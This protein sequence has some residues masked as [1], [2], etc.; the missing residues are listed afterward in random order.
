MT[1]TKQHLDLKV[2]RD[3]SVLNEKDKKGINDFLNT[4]AKKSKC[5][6]NNVCDCKGKDKRCLAL[7]PEM[8]SYKKPIDSSYRNVCPCSI[9]Y[10]KD[11]IKIAKEAI[12]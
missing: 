6:F 8:K 3:F 4:N 12:K 10:I 5:P 2:K 7:F 11:V 9:L 1:L